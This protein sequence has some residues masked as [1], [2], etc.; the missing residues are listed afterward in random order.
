MPSISSFYGITIYMYYLGKEHN[1][2][3]IHAYYGENNAIISI[4]NGKIIE[5]SLPINALKLVKKWVKIHR[6]ELE[7]MWNSQIFKKIAP[8]D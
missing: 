3:H 2:S 1:P 7:I 4:Q 5:G 6:E 8:L